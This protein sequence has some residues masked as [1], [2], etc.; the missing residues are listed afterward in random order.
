MFMEKMQ[1]YFQVSMPFTMQ[2]NFHLNVPN[3]HY[4]IKIFCKFQTLK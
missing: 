2:N 1:E 4:S 3:F